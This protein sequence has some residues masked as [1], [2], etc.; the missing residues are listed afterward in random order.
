MIRLIAASSFV[1]LWLCAGMAQG[2]GAEGAQVPT[3][4][5]QVVAQ[6]ARAFAGVNKSKELNLAAAEESAQQVTMVD[7]MTPFLA[8]SINGHQMWRVEFKGISVSQQGDSVRTTGGH[9]RDF[10]VYIDPD[11]PGFVKVVSQV[12][13]Y[14]EAA[15]HKPRAADGEKQLLRRGEKYVGLPTSGPSVG[16]LDAMRV[17][18]SYSDKAEEVVGVYVLFSHLG[19]DPLPVWDIHMYGVP[20]SSWAIRQ[21]PLPT[22][23]TNHMR[24][25]INAVT[26]EVLFGEPVPFPTD[27]PGDIR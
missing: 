27:G 24:T 22:Y 11:Q 15:W 13:G 10:V 8:D 26:G 6:A 2:Q 21:G 7:S 23:K 25:I 16:F 9:P 14:D 3:S 19:K 18:M 17:A 4:V 5:S 12:A 20:A 1:W